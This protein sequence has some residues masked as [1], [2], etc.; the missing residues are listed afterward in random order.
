MHKVRLSTQIYTRKYVFP[1][2][3]EVKVLEHMSNLLSISAFIEEV[4][5]QGQVLFSFFHQPHELKIWKDLLHNQEENLRTRKQTISCILAPNPRSYTQHC[6]GRI[7]PCNLQT[8]KT[9]PAPQVLVGFLQYHNTTDDV[10]PWSCNT[11]FGLYFPHR[12]ISEL[13]DSTD[14]KGSP[15]ACC[16]QVREQSPGEQTTWPHLTKGT[17]QER[18]SSEPH[19]ST[20]SAS[21]EQPSDNAEEEDL[22]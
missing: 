9:Q 3:Q 6:F 14:T 17:A 12:Y 19:S 7:I 18:L 15:A 10:M 22:K 5:L 21:F 13:N 4:Q 1:H 11:N 8:K 16:L 2:L 20:S